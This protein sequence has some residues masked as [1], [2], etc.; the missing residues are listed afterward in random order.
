MSS[1]AFGASA[2]FS[3]WLK[4]QWKNALTSKCELE[5]RHF[6]ILHRSAKRV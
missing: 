2:D 3:S 5:R 1:V 4:K 6:D